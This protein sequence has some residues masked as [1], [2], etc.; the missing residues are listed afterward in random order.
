MEKMLKVSDF[1][2]W[3]VGSARHAEKMLAGLENESVILDFKGVQSISQHFAKALLKISADKKIGINYI[4][5]NND[6]SR[7]LDFADKMGA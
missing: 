2:Y 7:M 6:V 5:V 1:L 4:N 3:S